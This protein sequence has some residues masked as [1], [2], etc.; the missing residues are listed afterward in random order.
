MGYTTKFRGSF[1][2]TPPLNP[3]Q[4]A[5]INKF[6]ETR[7]M[8]RD[9]KITAA[10]P[11]PIRDAVGLPVGIEGGYFVGAAGDFGQE[12]DGWGESR[13]ATMKA[14]GI[15]DYNDPPAG[16]PGLWCQW[17]VSEDGTAIK[18]DEEEKFYD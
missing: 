13:N 18:W 17:E 5:Y 4:V 1:T 10:R 7:R 6:R 2:V 16:Q 12:G 3:A 11:D 9:A 15:L 14:L 8:K